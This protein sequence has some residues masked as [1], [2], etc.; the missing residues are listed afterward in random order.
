MALD[1]DIK[2]WKYENYV[3]P[4][5]T[6][7][8]DTPKL[9]HDQVEELL[10]VASEVGFRDSASVRRRMGVNGAAALSVYEVA[11]WY[12][13]GSKNRK[14][15]KQQ[16]PED[17]IDKAYTGWYLRIPEGGFIDKIATW[18]DKAVQNIYHFS[19]ALHDNQHIIIDDVP[20]VFNKGDVLWFNIR[21]T[22]EIPRTES[23]QL[24]ACI[25]VAEY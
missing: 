8:N 6:F 7:T 21:S 1:T 24:W 12:F 23:E 17:K 16:F 5:S 10:R 20:H 9:T 4:Y 25:L 22:Y 15:F 3:L 19:V 2:C 18:V 13:F 11:K 14:A